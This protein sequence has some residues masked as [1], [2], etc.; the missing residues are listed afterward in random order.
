[1]SIGV[2]LIAL[3]AFLAVC[4]AVIGWIFRTGWRLKN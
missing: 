3:A 1:V 4:L 2:S